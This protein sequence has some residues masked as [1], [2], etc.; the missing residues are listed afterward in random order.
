MP[1]RFW[2]QTNVTSFYIRF[3]IFPINQLLSF[4]DSKMTYK[5][6]IVMPIEQLGTDNFG[7]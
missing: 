7:I 3:N 4:I 1:Y 2:R 6:I 5:K